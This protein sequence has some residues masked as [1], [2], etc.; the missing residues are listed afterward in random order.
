MTTQS[1]IDHIKSQ[2]GCELENCTAFGGKV[3]T[4]SGKKFAVFM[5][6]PQD[7]DKVERICGKKS[8]IKNMQP[9]GLN[10]VAIYI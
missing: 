2:I 8:M 4:K 5:I 1:I 3:K 6:K 7:R 10:R 9:N